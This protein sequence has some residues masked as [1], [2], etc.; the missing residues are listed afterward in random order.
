MT[1]VGFC[2][3]L[4]ISVALSNLCQIVMKLS[5]RTKEIS[6]LIGYGHIQFQRGNRHQSTIPHIYKHGQRGLKREYIQKMLTVTV[7]VIGV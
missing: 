4:E 5:S 7:C 3:Y 2:L 1:L 6:L